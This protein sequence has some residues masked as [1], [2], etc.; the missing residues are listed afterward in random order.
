MVFKG[1]WSSVLDGWPLRLIFQKGIKIYNQQ[2][3]IVWNHVFCYSW[4]RNLSFSLNSKYL[5]SPLAWLWSFVNVV[6]KKWECLLWLTRR[7]KSLHKEKKKSITPQIDIM[8]KKSGIIFN[9]KV[10]IN[11]LLHWRTRMI[12]NPHRCL[13]K[14]SHNLELSIDIYS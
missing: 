6:L 13:H 12:D 9:M 10:E 7:W 11:S 3:T 8:K 1:L 4:V 5:P 2:E 14:M